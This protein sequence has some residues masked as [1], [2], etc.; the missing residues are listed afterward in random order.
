MNQIKIEHPRDGDTSTHLTSAVA[1]SA[2]SSTVKNNAG[3]ATNDLVRFGDLGEETAEIVTLTSTSGSATLGHTTGPSFAHGVSTPVT[4]MNYDQVMVYSS[5]SKTGDYTPLATIDI[6]VSS[7]YTIYQDADGDNDTWYK[8]R[9]KNS[10]ATTYSGYSPASQATGYP[11]ASL[12]YMIEMAAEELG[13]SNYKQYS[14]SLLKKYLNAGQM[15][16][17]QA[18]AQ[19]HGHHL[20]SYT[21]QSLTTG[22]SEYDLPTNFLAFRKVTVNFTGGSSNYMARF[23]REDAVRP[24]DDFYSNDPLIFLRGTQFHLEPSDDITTGG[25]VY[26]WYHKAPTRMTDDDDE[27]GLPY[28]AASVLVPFACYRALKSK[29]ETED[30]NNYKEEYLEARTEYLHM[31]SESGQDTMAKEVTIV[32]SD[33]YDIVDYEA[34][35]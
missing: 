20:I 5:T 14:R 3:F 18:I 30:A 6:D 24:S 11:V 7:E 1:A 26:M 33:L 23:K 4:E 34:T 16:M 8:T 13:D 12:G 27:H 17:A 9:F 31:L 15:I 25:T 29:G 19:L 10:V 32:D 2:A 35:S 21:T 28:G 22:T